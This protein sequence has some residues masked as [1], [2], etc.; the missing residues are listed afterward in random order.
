MEDGNLYTKSPQ[1]CCTRIVNSS[2]SHSSSA[3]GKKSRF[4]TRRV[5]PAGH[6]RGSSHKNARR[7]HY[8]DAHPPYYDAPHGRTWDVYDR[9]RKIL[10]LQELNVRSERDNYNQN[11]RLVIV[12]SRSKS[13][14]KIM[15]TNAYTN[16]H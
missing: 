5:L 4:Y 3:L 16:S 11:K 9:Q 15:Y 13:L 6:N 12:K 2:K 10:M 7:V 8:R 1:L 14:T